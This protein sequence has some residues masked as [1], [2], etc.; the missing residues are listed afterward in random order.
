MYVCVS[1]QAVRLSKILLK[2]VLNTAKITSS[3]NF[4]MSVFGSISSSESFERV[5]ITGITQRSISISNRRKEKIKK[6]QQNK[7]RIVVL[8][9]L[10]SNYL[11]KVAMVSTL[12]I[13]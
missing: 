8:Y 10:N 6:C 13:R 1:N 4:E 7:L 3:L 11:F 2:I 12:I 5:F 9:T